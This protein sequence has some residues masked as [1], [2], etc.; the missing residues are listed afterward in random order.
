MKVFEPDQEGEFVRRPNRFLSEISVDG[1]IVEAHC[2]NPGRL[3]EI[4]LPGTPVFLEKRRN[5]NKKSKTA[6]TLV[7]ARHKGKVIPL[8]AG[9]ANDAAEKLVLPKLFPGLTDLKREYSHG[10][11]RFDFHFYHKGVEIFLEV[12]S[13]TL[14]EEGTAMF[15]D[16]PT[17]RGLKHLEELAGIHNPGVKE[18][19]IL[20]LIS[21]GDSRRFIPNFH[22]DPD[23]AISLKNQQHHL[24]LHAASVSG[25]KS[26]LLTLENEEVPIEMDAIRAAEKNRGLYIL[27]FRLLENLKV[28]IG[29]L[30]PVSFSAGHYVYIG[31]S[32]RNLR[33]VAARYR[34]EERRKKEYHIDYLLPK[35]VERKVLPVYSTEQ[36]ECALAAELQ[37]LA[38][39]SIFGFGNTDCRCPS[40]LFYFESQPFNRREFVDLFFRFRHKEACPEP[41][42]ASL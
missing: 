20:F 17:E 22:T 25:D 36:L 7:G 16:A 33:Q 32:Q 27:Q 3:L 4:L 15:P 28:E 42:A 38:D 21:H 31:S 29:E 6:Y 35:T 37:P 30:G 13:C 40:H 12:K 41:P 5:N 24:G 2:P 34:R 18:G 11:S 19:H 10:N 14:S 23:F 39:K 26:G 9:R 1:R 8:Y